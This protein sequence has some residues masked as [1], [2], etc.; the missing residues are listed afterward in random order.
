MK[1]VILLF[2]TLILFSC[3]DSKF[4]NL[5][6]TA[7]GHVLF[8]KNIVIH[9]SIKKGSRRI[10][11][12]GALRDETQTL[13]VFNDT[14]FFEKI[15]NSVYETFI[16]TVNLPN[17]PLDKR[18]PSCESVFPS[19]K[20][21]Y[22]YQSQITELGEFDFNAFELADCLESQDLEQ[23]ITGYFEFYINNWQPLPSNDTKRFYSESLGYHWTH[24]VSDSE[25]SYFVIRL[26]V[27]L[28][29]LNGQLLDYRVIESETSMASYEID[30][31]DLSGLDML[32]F[33]L[34]ENALNDFLEELTYQLVL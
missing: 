5:D 10:A 7:I 12:N 20:S 30:S 22:L 24:Q 26:H 28:Y 27:R 21:L 34:F 13:S 3:Q 14:L 8:D 33:P 29:D 9:T 23:I 25:P 6:R 1:P 32:T 31:K 19:V 17:K 15:A 16:D 18:S 2:L 11:L 4:K